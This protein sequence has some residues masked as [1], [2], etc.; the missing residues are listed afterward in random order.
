MITRSTL[1][2]RVAVLLLLTLSF[3][4]AQAALPS[5]DPLNYAVGTNL[6]SLTNTDNT[7]WFGVNTSDVTNPAPVIQAGSLSYYGFPASS[8]NSVLVQ[9]VIGPGSRYSFT[10][11]VTSGTVYYS[12]LMRVL[13]I[14]P[15][16]TGTGAFF[17]GL[18]NSTGTQTSQPSIVGSRVETRAV[19]NGG[20]TNGYNVGLDK[21]S[22]AGAN[23]Q[24]ATNLFTTNDVVLIVGAYTFNTGTTSDD[25]SQ[26]WVNPDAS[27]FGAATAPAANVLAVTAGNDL[28]SASSF[29]ILERATNTQPASLLV[30]EVRIGRNWADVVPP[31]PPKLT[32]FLAP[33][34]IVF[35]WPTNAVGFKLESTTNLLSVGTPWIATGDPVI[36]SNNQNTVTETIDTTTNRFFRLHQTGP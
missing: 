36:I 12:F 15:Y 18:N 5:Y 1:P 4:T 16:L 11:A 22:G 23:F 7:V 2:T 29:L 34:N 21:T 25:V 31:G 17:A 20:V 13:D 35:S 19:V 14:G 6:A 26:L 10:P 32:V 3:L 33:P 8:G 27:T 24:W 30:D 9:N 28:A